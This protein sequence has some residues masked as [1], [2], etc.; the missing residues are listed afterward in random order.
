MKRILFLLTNLAGG[1]A[2]KVL[3]DI[4]RHTDFERYEVDLLLVV[5]EGV[6]LDSLPA[7]VST[8]SLYEQRGLKYK[9]DFFFSRYWGMDFFQ[10]RLIKKR[11]GKRYDVIVSF[12]EG[13]PLKFHKYILDR[14]QVNISW[15]HTDMERLHYT[16]KYFRKHEEQ[17]LYAQMNKVIV[18]SQQAQKG[19]GKVFKIHTPVYALYNPIDRDLIIALANAMSVTKSKLTICSVG[20]LTYAKRYDR[21]IRAIGKLMNCG[22]NVELWIIGNGG[23]EKQLRK[24]T[25]ELNI[26]KHV[27]FLGFQSNPYPYVK[28]ADIFLSTSMTEGYPLVICEALCLGKP[29]V[30]TNVTGPREILG[31]SEYGLLI[32]EDDDAI[33]AGICRMIDDEALRA[34]YA[35]KACERKQ[36]FEIQPVV[37]KIYNIICAPSHD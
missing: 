26:E 22:Y 10:S 15:V 29:I 7:Q 20:R 23:L 6:Y 32:E 27:K 8:Y 37:D 3:V 18:V 12:M 9:L 5:N 31:D 25:E 2:E 28:A 13:I 16:A 35:A 14:G 34:H 4:L 36:V 1:G 24:Q 30:A 11:I 33:F 19:F 21:A 17:Q